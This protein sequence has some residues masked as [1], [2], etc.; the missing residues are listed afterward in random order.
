MLRRSATPTVT[1][2]ARVAGVGLVTTVVVLIAACLTFMLQQWAVART[3]S[4][5]FHESLA[6]MS[7]TLAAPAMAPAERVRLGQALAAVQASKEVAVRTRRRR[8]GTRTGQL[9]RQ[10]LAPAGPT[11]IIRRPVLQDGKTVGQRQPHRRAAVA[12]RRCCRS[13]SP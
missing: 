11:E 1:F 9:S 4:H 12:A 3:Q 5:R 10:R 7:A 6:E 8:R 2:H 13:S